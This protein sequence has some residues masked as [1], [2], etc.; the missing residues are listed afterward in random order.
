MPRFCY[1]HDVCLSVF[2]SVTWAD[3]NHTVEQKVEMGTLQDR[4]VSWLPACRSISGS[5]YPL[6]R[7]MVKNAM[8]C[9]LASFNG[10]PVALSQHLLSYLF[11]SVRNKSAVEAIQTYKQ[12]VRSLHAVGLSCIA[13]PTCRK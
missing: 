7:I 1:E 2:L 4:S 10:S 13:R 3:C 5:W 8:F 9:T 6:S 12:S 11:E